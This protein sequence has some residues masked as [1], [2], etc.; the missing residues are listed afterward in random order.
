MD[1]KFLS[2]GGNDTTVGESLKTQL[3]AMGFGAKYMPAILAFLGMADTPSN[4][5]IVYGA[6]S[7]AC[8]HIYL[9]FKK[10]YGPDIPK[11]TAG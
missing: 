11:P 8:I 4:E 9:W 5:I 6:I 10:T 7:Q 2:N 3:I 1:I